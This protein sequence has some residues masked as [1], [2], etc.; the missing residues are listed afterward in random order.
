LDE[1]GNRGAPAAI[2]A[3]ISSICGAVRLRSARAGGIRTARSDEVMHRTIS[4]APDRMRNE[5]TSQHPGKRRHDCDEPQGCAP[6]RGLP[7]PEWR[8]SDKALESGNA[9]GF[10]TPPTRLPYHAEFFRGGYV[11]KQQLQR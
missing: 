3:R 8:R 2:E 10:M 11:T 9:C 6:Y 4:L 5:R 7:C 1:E